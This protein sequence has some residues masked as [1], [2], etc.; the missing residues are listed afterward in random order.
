LIA[1]AL[2]LIALAGAQVWAAPQIV[3]RPLSFQ[4]MHTY[5][6][7]TAEDEP[8]LQRSSGLF[9]VGVGTPVYLEVQVEK[10]AVVVGDVTWS[11]SGPG[12]ASLG[13]SP[14]A[15]D[16]VPIYN[17]GEAEDN[18]VVSRRELKPDAE[19]Q[20]TVTAT[21]TMETTDADGNTQSESVTLEEVVTAG[22]YIGAAACITCHE[23][24][25]P[26]TGTADGPGV[27]WPTTGHSTFF[28]EAIDGLK[29]DHYSSA[30][31]DCHTVGYDE[32]PAAVNGGFDDV[33]AT[34]G[35]TFPET[36]QPGNWDAMPA[37]LQ[38]KA[39]IQC[40][41]CHGPGSQ[42]NGNKADNRISKTLSA[43]DCSFCHDERPYHSKGEE[44][45]NSGHAKATRYP[46]GEGEEACVVCHSGIGFV[47]RIEKGLDITQADYAS[48][49]TDP[50]W[51]AI[52][53]AT[54]HDP[55]LASDDHPHQLRRVAD[56]ELINGQMITEGG[57]GKVCMN[58]HKA[59]RGGEEYASIYH[60]RH[61]P[62][63]SNQ[64]DMLVGE[65]AVEYGKQIRKSSHVYAVQD[66]CVG[67][68]MQPVSNTDPKFTK[69]GGHT[70]KPVFD[71][72]TP[73][74]PSDDVDLTAACAN[75]HGPMTSFDIPKSDYDGDG[76][77]EGVQTEV[78]GLME[79]L[80]KALPPVGQNSIAISQD[81]TEKQLKATFNYNF[82][83]NDGSH[84]IHN[85]QYAVGILKAS[86]EDV[87]GKTISTGGG[88]R[89]LSGTPPKRGGLVASAAPA[90]KLV[91]GQYELYQNAPNPFNP[92]TEIRYAVPE[93]ASVRIEI[94]NSLGQKVRTLVD[95]H[96]A[97]GEY[98]ATWNGRDAD[99]Q[100][101]TA[102]M[103]IYTI[104]AGS[105]TG[106][107]KMVLLP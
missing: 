92:E 50:T 39:N 26:F 16:T 61:D 42:H 54:C 48:Q 1:V 41:N 64:T 59:R 68:H 17:P 70:F 4:E 47:E 53:C 38:A 103:Y 60:S 85:T 63:H 67:C 5:G 98:S 97:V 14:L 19:G 93:P 66:A 82:V 89:V 25:P 100:P 51:E 18:K 84:G 55:H 57:N 7:V 43:G 8:A 65:S 104:Q 22:T 31:I 12:S 76:K 71:N 20:W 37:E 45:L 88:V 81:F 69:V 32:D 78:E 87:T 86:I 28:T 35:W 73:D 58:C 44:W 107:G 2:A 95:A 83:V 33:A 62:H 52:T 101:V 75:C 10:A 13:D 11:V 27:Q 106:N 40:E 94:Y 91:P 74:D 79:I 21:L 46:S 90:G 24:H 72:G 96:H 9:T 15:I 49:I 80:A 29:S 56:V 102:G 34:V 3:S 30:C 77:V 23:K 36:L 6:L 105:F 99:G